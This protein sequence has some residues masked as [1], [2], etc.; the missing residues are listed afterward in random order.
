[1]PEECRRLFD[2]ATASAGISTRGIENMTGHRI[3]A[4]AWFLAREWGEAD[5]E[6]AVRE[7]L[8]AHYEP[9]WDRKRG[10]FTW[11]LGLG[12]EYPRG[13][14]NGFLAAAEA[15]SP[16]AWTRLS[17][18]PLPEQPG[19]V[20]GVDFPALAL[21]EAR[22]E[23]GA[24]HLRLH[25]QSD[26]VVGRPTRFRISGLSNAPDPK[27]WQLTGNARLSA[28]GADLVVETTIREGRLVVRP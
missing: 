25:P 23:S 18:A 9:T 6:A 15:G 10:E 28:D 7:A 12:E 2:S 21:S 14:Y 27:N 4:I 19:L 24:L 5:L 13:Q 3:N 26:Q 17:E 8:E 1:V 16:G 20:E 22:W 11:G